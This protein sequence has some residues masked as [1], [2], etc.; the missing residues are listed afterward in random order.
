MPRNIMAG[1]RLYRKCSA[2]GSGGL[3]F[4]VSHHENTHPLAA[5]LSAEDV[6]LTL[7]AFGDTLQEAKK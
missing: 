3:S 1:D 4:R 5:A 7:E 2:R 6:A